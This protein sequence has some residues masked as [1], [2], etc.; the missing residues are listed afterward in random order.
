MRRNA[1]CV[2]ASETDVV[3]LLA[4]SDGARARRRLEKA[5]L[6]LPLLLISVSVVL[7]AYD[8]GLLVG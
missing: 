4:A 7:Y 8:A 6:L 5:S 2:G 1:T 3:L